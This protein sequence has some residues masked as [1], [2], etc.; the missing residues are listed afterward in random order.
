AQFDVE[1][2]LKPS[3][4]KLLLILGEESPKDAYQFR[5]NVA[6]GKELGVDPVMFPGEHVSH[7]THAPQFSERLVE[8]LKGRDEFY[9]KL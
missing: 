1:R 3:K 5:A 6:L 7:A 9:R 2:E 4:E 8:V